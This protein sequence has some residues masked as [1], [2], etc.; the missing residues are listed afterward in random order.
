MH[1]EKINN[2]QLFLILTVMRLTVIIA[3]LP[4]LTSADALQDAWVAALL[5]FFPAAF[6]IFLITWLGKRYPEE[7]LIEYS[8]KLLGKWVGR[9]VGFL[10]LLTFLFMAGSDLRVYTEVI[11]TGFLTNTPLIA[12]LI[13]MVVISSV[14]AFYG[15]EVIGRIADFLFPILAV[16]VVVS[17]IIAIPSV[18]FGKINLQPV[19]ARGLG[20]VLRGSVVPTSIIA[21]YLVLTILIPAINKPQK[22]FLAA[23]GALGLATVILILFALAVVIVLG[24]ESGARQLFPVFAMVRN[25]Q[26]S[27]FLERFEALTIFGWGFGLFISVSTFLYCGAK[28]LAKLMKLGS[29]RPLILPMAVIWVAFSFHEYRDIF[30]LE[31]VFRPNF[32]GPFVLSW[33]LLSIFPLCL[34]SLI[35]NIKGGKK[36][37]KGR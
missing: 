34:A 12:I 37:G 27:T 4:A 23:F 29:Y 35:K 7:T 14:A 25:L 22:P 1:L 18:R 15:I 2:R 11:T 13:G 32:I 20:P 36:D 5:A 16:A 3:F 6:I 19:L 21:Q 17:L 24:P 9:L 31:E 33:F 10:V 28:G 8:Q 30:A 26:I